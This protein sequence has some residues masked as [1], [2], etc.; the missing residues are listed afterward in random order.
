M[1]LRTLFMKLPDGEWSTGK[2]YL[3]TDKDSKNK[4]SSMVNSAVHQ[5]KIRWVRVIQSARDSTN[6]VDLFYQNSI[7]SLDNIGK[8]IQCSK[9]KSIL[10]A[11]N[12]IKTLRE[13]EKKMKKC[14]FFMVE[15]NICFCKKAKN[16]MVQYCIPSPEKGEGNT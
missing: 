14:K 4:I 13:R 9:I 3:P 6:V 5:F 2:C 11:V 16:G 12:T 7:E 10:V 1:T 15:V 8:C